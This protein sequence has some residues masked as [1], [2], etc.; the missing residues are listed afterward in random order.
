MTLQG[1]VQKAVLKNPEYAKVTLHLNDK[2]FS[3][4]LI[5]VGLLFLPGPRPKIIQIPNC[6]L[7]EG[8]L[9]DVDAYNESRKEEKK[10]AFEEMVK[11]RESKRLDTMQ[12]DAPGPSLEKMMKDVERRQKIHSIFDKPEENSDFKDEK[13]KYSQR[14]T[15]RSLYR[16]FKKVGLFFLLLIP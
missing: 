3:C 16:E 2:A 13:T 10:K 12:V 1:G 15:H 7:K 9:K 4:T 14:N 8:F 6:P 11:V 5:N